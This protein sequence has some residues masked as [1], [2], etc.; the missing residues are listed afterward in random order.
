M[1]LLWRRRRGCFEDPSARD[2]HESGS[3]RQANPCLWT[4]RQTYGGHDAE[5]ADNPLDPVC[6]CRSGRSLASCC[7]N[8]PGGEYGD[9]DVDVALRELVRY[10]GRGEFSAAIRRIAE[11]VAEPLDP[12]L[13][14][15]LSEHFDLDRRLMCL[16]AACTERPVRGGESV[17]ALLVRK[18]G[19]RLPAR[20]R[21]L[22]AQWAAQPF[23]LYEVLEVF[24]GQG[25]VLRDRL[26]KL[27]VRVAEVAGSRQIRPGWWM[28]VRVRTRPDGTP[29]MD[30]PILA[31]PVPARRAIEEWLAEIDDEQPI[32]PREH[33]I[34]LFHLWQMSIGDALEAPPPDIVDRD[35]NP[36]VICEAKYTIRDPEAFV[37]AVARQAGFK[38]DESPEQTERAWDWSE[39]GDDDGRRVLGRLELAG[40]RAV[41]RAFSREQI[42]RGRSLLESIA[43]VE[44][45]AVSE[46]DPREL[47]GQDEADAGEAPGEVPGVD[48]GDEVVQQMLDRHYRKWVDEPVPMFGGRTPRQM[49]KVDPEAVAREIW[50]ISHGPKGGPQYDADWMY[51]ELGVR[52]LGGGPFEAGVAG[53]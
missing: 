42:G 26:R 38:P 35:G 28:A 4:R 14:E 45:V 17:A 19:A 13:D 11:A 33:A 25:I 5:M 15:Y 51:A 32:D 24:E 18:E 1:P 3:E 48:L 43:G 27:T 40:H 21:A 46:T 8:V 50:S 30:P 22:L 37:Q 23:S 36:V 7:A 20:S 9:D 34:D 41:L 53:G 44:F 52:R 12:E 2:H 31:F 10:S 47:L 16:Y 6:P 39:P 49:A 29:V